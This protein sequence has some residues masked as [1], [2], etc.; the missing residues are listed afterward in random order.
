MADK[1][2]SSFLQNVV[3]EFRPGCRNLQRSQI[4]VNFVGH[5]PGWDDA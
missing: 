4:M 1:G 3:E 2:K 5:I